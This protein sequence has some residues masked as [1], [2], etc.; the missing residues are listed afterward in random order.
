[1]ISTTEAIIL[2]SVKYRDSG[3]LLTVYT[4]EFGRC[5][6]IANGARKAKNKFGSALEPMS[7]ST[8]TFYKRLGKDLHTL[9]GAE[10]AVPMRNLMDSFDRMTTGLAIC[11]TVHSTQTHEE[12][13][14]AI[15]TLLKQSLL[16]LNAGEGNEQTL[17]AWFQAHYAAQLGFRLAPDFCAAS[18][19]AVSPSDAP[20]FVL[21]LADGA[22]YSPAF[23]QVNTGFRM[24]AGTLAILQRL[25]HIPPE[26]AL[27]IALSERQH[28][29]LSDFLTLYYQFHLDRTVSDRS[30]RFMQ[31]AQ[32]L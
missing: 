14:L 21:S 16:A 13:N 9:S 26:Q 12:Q 6:L 24:D 8:L 18:G 15:F 32:G 10:T 1:M 29:Q 25:L 4:A 20:Q 30:R 11:E 19:E 2:K 22:P 27:R 17:L 5:S 3:K 28:T 23:A 31:A 7:C